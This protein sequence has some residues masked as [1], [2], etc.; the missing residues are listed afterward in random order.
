MRC[1]REDEWHQYFDRDARQEFCVRV[2]A[3]VA[4]CQAC[5]RERERVGKMNAMSRSLLTSLDERS[6]ELDVE[7]AHLQFQA[8]LAAQRSG[9]RHWWGI[10]VA[11]G[12]AAVAIGDWHMRRR[13]NLPRAVN[14]STSVM[15]TR[16]EGGGSTEFWPLGPGYPFQIG[17]VVRVTL[18]ARSSVNGPLQAAMGEDVG[19]GSAAHAELLIG[20]DGFVH[21]LHTM[22]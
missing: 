2:D 14:P 17:L 7:S 4:Q 9:H 21:G 1:L 8:R 12:L 22:R 16:T 3:H 11:A 10:A 20:D 5:E 19:L 13:V 6:H 15:V 18:R